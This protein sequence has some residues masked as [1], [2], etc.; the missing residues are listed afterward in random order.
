MLPMTTGEFESNL[1]VRT[2]E[3]INKT[4]RAVVKTLCCMFGLA[5]FP[6]IEF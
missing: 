3:T 2:L 5:R 4:S 1:G 6:D